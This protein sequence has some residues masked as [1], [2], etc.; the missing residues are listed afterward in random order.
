MV[1]NAVEK[2]QGVC[3]KKNKMKFKKIPYEQLNARQQEN[4]DYHKIT[5]KLADYGY[6]CSRLSD[7]WQGADFIAIHIDGKSFVKVQQKGRFEVD[8]LRYKGKKIWIAFRDNHSNRIFI[9]PHDKALKHVEDGITNKNAIFWITFRRNWNKIT[10]R[11]MEFLSN[12]E[13]K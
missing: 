2:N 6:S 11:N 12:Y 8:G 10:K 3:K 7:D 4:Y 1:K 9:Y 13:L 5:G